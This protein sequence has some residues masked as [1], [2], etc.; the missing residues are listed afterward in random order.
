MQ[1]HVRTIMNDHVITAG[2]DDSLL[3]LARE[4]ATHG[5]SAVPIVDGEQQLVGIVSSTDLVS[6]LNDGGRLVGKRA[7]DVM[8]EK[9]ISIDEFATAA[10]AIGVMRNALIGHLPVTRENKLVGL[11]TAS[12]LIR[13]L[14]KSFPA[15]EVA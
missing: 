8:S 10:E 13:H 11:V 3:D 9:P 6:L 4:I 7:R 1:A 15:P 12:D 14:L 2:P 5:I